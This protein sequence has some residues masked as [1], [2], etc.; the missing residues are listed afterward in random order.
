M[1][2]IAPSNELNAIQ[3]KNKFHEKYFLCFITNFI[4]FCHRMEE[5]IIA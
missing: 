1:Q 5:K 4:E 2:N 3:Q